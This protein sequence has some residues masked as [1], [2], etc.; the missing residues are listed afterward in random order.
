MKMIKLMRALREGALNFYRDMWLTVATVT[1][2]VL[3]LFLIGTTLLLGF[4]ISETITS[5]EKRINISI[6]FNHDTE[7][8]TITQIKEDLEDRNLKEI[9]KIVYISRD[10]ALDRMKEFSENDPDMQKALSLLDENPLRDALVITASETGDYEKI[11]KFFGQEYAA[12][13]AETSYDKSR[14][15]ISV[16]RDQMIFV[17]NITLGLSLLFIVI[18]VLVTFNTIRMSIYVHRKEYEVM[19][20]VGA[21]NLYVRIPVVAEGVLYGLVSG[22]LTILLLLMGLAALQ[23]T[24]AGLFPES[25]NILLVYRNSIAMILLII[26]STGIFLGLSGSYIAIRRYLER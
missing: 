17:R 13:I 10:E 9:Q 20:L 2:M 19:R 4:G 6:Y 22:L 1:V 5:I 7:E 14:D 16:L 11:N 25:N 23:P 12:D 26:V 3:T 8:E 18:A 21:S 24:L 15:T